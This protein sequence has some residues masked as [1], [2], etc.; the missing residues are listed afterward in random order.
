MKQ[1]RPST[2]QRWGFGPT[3]H[4]GVFTRGCV[5]GRLV[6]PT[7]LMRRSAT[8]CAAVCIAAP[9]APS[10]HGSNNIPPRARL[11]YRN[12]LKPS[13][14]R[15]TAVHRVAPR[16]AVGRS[17]LTRRGCWAGV[18]VRGIVCY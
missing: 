9:L 3:A 1:R 16:G 13:Y 11:G 15:G 4:V 12:Y 7:P 2:A 8:R 5:V 10:L 18:S 14:S 6:R 17:F